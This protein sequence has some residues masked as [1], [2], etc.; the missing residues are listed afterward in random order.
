MLTLSLAAK[1]LRNRMLTTSLTVASIALSVALLVGIENIRTGMRESFSQTISQ[2]DL[3]VGARG[4]ST[5]LLLYSV[6]GLG[7]PT[8]GLSWETYERIRE[9]PA[10]AW[11]I[12][13]SLGDSHRGYRVIGTTEAFYEH[14]RFRGDQAVEFAVGRAAE[15][16]DE[17]VVG[18]DVARQ[19]GYV[20]GHQVELSHGMGPMSFVTHDEHPFKVVGVLAPTF[21]PID[22]SLYVTLE[23]IEAMHEGFASA[24]AAPIGFGPGPGGQPSLAPPPMPGAASPPAE[25]PASAAPLSSATAPGVAV[26][27]ADHDHA[28]EAISSFFVGTRSRV[29]AL[30]L[31]QEINT[32]E[33]EPLMAV[34]PGI[35][36]A[37]M[38]RTVGYAEDALKIVTGFV[39]VVGLLGMIVSLYTSL[40]ERRRE[41]A[42]LRAI[43]ARRGRI[44]SLLVL[45]SGL[46]ATLGAM[47]GV[48]L[49]YLLLY[50]GQGPIER[51]FGLF[52][53]I[54]SLGPTELGYIGL[55]VGAGFLLGLIPALKAYRNALVDGLSIKV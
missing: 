6:F 50:L 53:P 47:L 18:A 37:E 55:I 42:I 1:S 14:Y 48:G 30:Q 35:A 51:Q 34:L 31:Q 38:W 54:R 49:V 19:L 13:Y 4:G 15:S 43:G 5:Q 2:T 8:G 23:G 52:V 28:V 25:S 20:P 40:N 45:E 11:T 10:V 24:G 29:D 41:M 33:D 7:S 16:A 12:P 9:H 44:V 36:L 3:I 17:V 46:L 26:E 32:F 27:D 21:T 39:V 22:R